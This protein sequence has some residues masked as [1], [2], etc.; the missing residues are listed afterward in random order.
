MSTM[1]QAELKAGVIFG[2]TINGEYV[3]MPASEIGLAAPIC[4][5]EAANR[6]DDIDLHE[7]MRLIRLRSLKPAVH[8]RLG[9]SSC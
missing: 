9:R 8:P 3:Y 4:V 7:A 2:D 1:V 6:R 5:Y